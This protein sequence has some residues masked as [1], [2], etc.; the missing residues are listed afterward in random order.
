[1]LMRPRGLAHLRS[2]GQRREPIA[3]GQSTD[4]A[5][6]THHSQV[7]SGCHVVPVTSRFRGSPSL[8]L[9]YADSDLP[10][11]ELF[12]SLLL[13]LRHWAFP[14]ERAHRGDRLLSGWATVLA[15]VSTE[16]GS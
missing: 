16:V 7:T 6:L 3:H 10:C 14:P 5:V 4:I 11:W 9:P 12:L 15:A 1:M 13:Y 2:S 8:M